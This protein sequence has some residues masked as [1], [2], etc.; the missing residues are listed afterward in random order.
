MENLEQFLDDYRLKIELLRKMMKTTKYFR[1]AK[2][3]ALDIHAITHSKSVS[4]LA[5]DT[6]FDQLIY[7]LTDEDYCV[8]PR[9]TDET[10]AWHIWHISRIEDIVGNLL[11]TKHEQVFSD[12]LKERMG[13]PVTDTANAMTDEDIISF[14]KQINK[15]ELLNYRNMVGLRTRQIISE[16][17]PADIRRKAEEVDLNRLLET[18]CLINQKESLFLRD[19]W[20]R[21]TF[22]GMLC[23]PLTRHHMMHLPDS[24]T[25]KQLIHT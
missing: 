21:L 23:L 17:T 20:G 25:I 13:T 6:F 1:V 9:D 5:E 3:L 11:M 2:Q 10:I 24:Y 12:E 19:F 7:G 15:A 22:G 14:S 18:G 8:M 4:G 16:L